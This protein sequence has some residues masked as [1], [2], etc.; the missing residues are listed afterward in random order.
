[1]AQILDK[2]DGNTIKPPSRG[3]KPPLSSRNKRINLNNTGGSI[4]GD[5]GSVARSSSG[6]RQFK[7]DA[8]RNRREMQNDHDYS[9]RNP[10]N[11][12]LVMKSAEGGIKSTIIETD[13]SDNFSVSS[14]NGRGGF[15][16]SNF[17]VTNS[18]GNPGIGG[19][20]M[21]SASANG[22]QINWS[23]I[24]TA[25]ASSNFTS[26]FSYVASMGELEDMDRLMAATGPVPE[27][28]F[29]FI[30]IN[31]TFGFQY[32]YYLFIYFLILSFIDSP[33]HCSQQSV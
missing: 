8:I 14:G 9:H 23:K 28:I 3:A 7:K 1:M 10:H 18:A 30:K 15:D 29:C 32:F 33:C 24:S 2:I 4:N 12:E 19:G 17:G 31:S 20:L 11:V 22:S 27:V 16:N 13:N 25:I 5:T 21:L 26:A 6:L